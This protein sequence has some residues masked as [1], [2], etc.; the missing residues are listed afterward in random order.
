MGHKLVLVS[1]CPNS[2]PFGGTK[3]PGSSLWPLNSVRRST[4][5]VRTEF[6][7]LNRLP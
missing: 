4:P 7:T 2:K 6:T 5:A 1:V 3:A